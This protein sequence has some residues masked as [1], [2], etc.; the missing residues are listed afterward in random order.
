MKTICPVGQKKTNTIIF[1]IISD[2]TSR[3]HPG[4]M[5]SLK[6]VFVLYGS[7]TKCV[8][9]LILSSPPY[10]V[11]TRTVTVTVTVTVTMLQQYIS[12]Y[13]SK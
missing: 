2:S 7:T 13:M 6:L 4:V 1:L 5:D 9:G 10:L 3:V 8:L 11:S 12:D